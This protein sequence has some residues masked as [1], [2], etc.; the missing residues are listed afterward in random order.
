M[1]PLVKE[2]LVHGLM[3][4]TAVRTAKKTSVSIAYY[5]TAGVI[6]FI[7]AGFFGFALYNAL[8]P[9]IGLAY[10]ALATGG[11]FTLIAVIIGVTGH[12]MVEG[13]KVLKK[14]AHD[15][16]FVDSV[17]HTVKSLMENF[18]DPVK[19]NPKLALLMA[20]LAGFA[21]GDKLGEKIH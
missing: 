3:A 1:S 18:E 16:G 2:L 9:A 21:A 8:S 17:E 15:G 7:A 12:Y 10:A 5:G 19:E 20:A 13:K 11:V 6:G 4:G 14:P